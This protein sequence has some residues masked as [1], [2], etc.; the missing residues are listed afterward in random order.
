MRRTLSN[1]IINK[2][3]GCLLFLCVLALPSYP[4]ASF[5]KERPIRQGSVEFSMGSYNMNEPRFDAVYPGGG[6][7][8]GVSISSALVSNVNFYLEIK[9]YQR[10]GALTFTKEKTEFILVP[11]SLGMRYIFPFG[12]INPYAG[13]G[14]DFYFYYE[15]NPIGTVLNYANGYHFLGGVYF[16]LHK[17]IPLLINLKVK[18]TS[19]RAKEN[20]VKI[21]LGGVEYSA[22]LAFVF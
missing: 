19:A 20:D 14:L 12:L 16:Q 18:H 1:R 15:N 6:R 11:I 3:L 7:I 2:G 9:A 22:S 17:K 5:F 10:K 21:Q 8:L 4:F 13:A